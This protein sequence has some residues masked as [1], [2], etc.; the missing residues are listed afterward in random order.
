MRTRRKNENRS[1]W[2]LTMEHMGRE[3]GKLY[4]PAD[5]PPG[6]HDLFKEE[7]RRGGAN[8]PKRSMAHKREGDGRLIVRTRI[9]SRTVFCSTVCGN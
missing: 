6:W 9:K 2:R 1:D 5:A 8:A 7:H 4:P 3:L